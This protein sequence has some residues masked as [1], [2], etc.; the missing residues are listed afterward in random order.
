MGYGVG[1]YWWESKK[2]RVKKATR[3]KKSRKSH[4][5]KEVHQ[6]NERKDEEK[7][8]PHEGKREI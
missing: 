4:Q 3:K 7:M 6:K 5:K 1:G 2:G 8:I